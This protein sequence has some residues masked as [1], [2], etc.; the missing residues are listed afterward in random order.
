MLAGTGRV[1]LDDLDLV[2]GFQA[3]ARRLADVAAA[4]DDDAFV[5][6]VQLAEFGITM[7]MFL[8]A[9]MKNTSS[10][11]SMTVLP[12]GND[13]PATAENRRHPCLHARHVVGQRAQ[14][15]PTSGPP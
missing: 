11:A 3:A 2:A 10:S 15:L 7:R 4:G 9:A 5:G 6:L 14:C 13:R 1:V 8:R 12:S